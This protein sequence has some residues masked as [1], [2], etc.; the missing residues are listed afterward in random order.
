M[1]L[2]F[3]VLFCCISTR[4]YCEVSVEKNVKETVINAKSP[5]H[6]GHKFLKYIY[7]INSGVKTYQLNYRRCQDPSHKN[8]KPGISRGAVDLLSGIGLQSP[9]GEGW[10]YHSF[11]DVVVNGISLGSY[12]AKNIEPILEENR[13]GVSFLWELPE[14]KVKIDFFMINQQDG[15]YATAEITPDTKVKDV[16]VE[17]CCFPSIIRRDG[18]RLVECSGH[19]FLQNAKEPYT[20]KLKPN[21]FWFLYKD[22]KYDASGFRN[23]RGPCAVVFEKG[24]PTGAV[25][26]VGAYSVRT[27]INY[28]AATR[29]IKMCFFEFQKLVNTD[30]EKYFLKQLPLVEKNLSSNKK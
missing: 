29:K 7:M 15:F 16:R 2:L 8:N 14:V 1:R 12:Q 28:P 5:H 4:A 20:L 19:K 17:L 22:E 18:K 10:Y 27:R 21:E 23:G 26:N 9:K 6:S 3:A 24:A 13:G 30:A 25:L 11:I